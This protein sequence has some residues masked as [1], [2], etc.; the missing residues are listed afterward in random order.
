MTIK[1]W[2]KAY[3]NGDFVSRDYE[4]QVKAGWYDWFCK[5]ASLARKTEAMAKILS[6]ITKP[7]LLDCEAIFANKCPASAH[8]LYEMMWIQ[9][10]DEKED[11]V[12]CI[13]IGDKRFD[14]R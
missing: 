2:V 10:H 13:S 12:F 14:H 6:R 7:E 1:D 3:K 11:T 8:P 4:T 9:T 5:T